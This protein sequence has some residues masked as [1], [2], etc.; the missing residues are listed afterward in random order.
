MTPSPI[1]ILTETGDQEIVDGGMTT[2]Q[3]EAEA[4][5]PASIAFVKRLLRWHATTCPM[6]KLR[7]WLVFGLGFM[8]AGQAAAVWIVQASLAAA[9][10]EVKEIVRTTVDQVLRERKIVGEAPAALPSVALVNTVGGA[11]R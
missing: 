10:A 4:N 11:T 5:N 1:G 9:R 8:V 3:L 7:I 6:K 2:E